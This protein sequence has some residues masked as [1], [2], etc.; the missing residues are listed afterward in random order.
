MNYPLLIRE[1]TDWELHNSYRPFFDCMHHL[2]NLELYTFDSKIP[3]NPNLNW[4]TW[5]IYMHQ[6]LWIDWLVNWLIT[7]EHT[8]LF[9]SPLIHN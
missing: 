7:D 8:R 4:L 9:D 5:V 3:L 2:Y 1:I 6:L